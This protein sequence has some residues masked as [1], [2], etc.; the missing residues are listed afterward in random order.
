M[1]PPALSL[2]IIKIMLQIKSLLRSSFPEE[3]LRDKNMSLMETY[4]HVIW[5]HS[6]HFLSANFGFGAINCVLA[7]LTLGLCVFVKRQASCSKARLDFPC[8]TLSF[9]R[10]LDPLIFLTP[11]ELAPT[12]KR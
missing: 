11:S 6:K 3:E 7:G 2:N 8:A 1:L 12:T 5:G 4:Q 10:G 9:T